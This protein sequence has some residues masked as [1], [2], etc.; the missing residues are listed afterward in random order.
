MWPLVLGGLLWWRR[1]SRRAV[2]AVCVAFAVA[3][4]VWMAIVLSTRRHQ[5]RLPRHRH[6]HP[7]AA[8]RRRARR[9]AA[10]EGPGHRAPRPDRRRGRGD[11]RARAAG[12]SCGSCCRTGSALLYRGGFF[13]CG[14]AAVAVLAADHPPEPGTGCPRPVRLRRSAGLG[15]ISYGLYLWHW[16]IFVLVDEAR[17]GLHG[18]GAHRRAAGHQPPGRRRVLL[19]RRDADPPPGPGRAGLAPLGSGARG[20]RRAGARPGDAQRTGRRVP[21]RRRPGRAAAADGGSDRRAAARGAEP[22]RAAAPTHRPASATDGGGRFRRWVPRRP[23]GGRR[24]RAADPDR[25]PR[26]RLLHARS[27][28]GPVAVDDGRAPSGGAG[29]PAVAAALGHRRGDLP[30][31][32]RADDLRRPQRRAAPHRRRLPRDVRGVHARLVPT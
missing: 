4:A 14:V 21:D 20:G 22:G 32:R 18:L 28:L 6:A 27:R 3:G 11:R 24:R 16:P 26:H 5:P 1:G 25:Q 19:R 7:G 2:F 30:A 31:R 23:D 17:T 9:V 15:L 8:A 10:V 12:R 29:L 13:L